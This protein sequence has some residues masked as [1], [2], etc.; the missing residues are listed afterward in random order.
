MIGENWQEKSGGPKG[1]RTVFLVAARLLEKL[2]C[3]DQRL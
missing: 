2:H 3:I 1:R